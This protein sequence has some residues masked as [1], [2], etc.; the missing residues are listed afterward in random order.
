[1]NI[2]STNRSAIQKEALDFLEYEEK[3]MRNYSI[4]QLRKKVLKGNIIHHTN[5]RETHS[6][7][8]E[9]I[10]NNHVEAVRNHAACHKT[11]LL[12][13]ITVA[14]FGLDMA[15]LTALAFPQGPMTLFGNINNLVGTEILPISRFKGDVNEFSKITGQIF[16]A[17][18]QTTDTVKQLFQSRNEGDKVEASAYESRMKMYMD[19]RHQEEQMA[20]RAEDEAHKDME[21]TRQEEAH[22]FSTL[23]R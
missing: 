2:I 11:N 13:A 7:L 15:Q 16:G 3:G 19:Q 1:M 14:K 6:N 23:A 12:F 20:Q 18:S 17:A 21:R 5:R 22:L 10:Q 8:S 4:E 9:K